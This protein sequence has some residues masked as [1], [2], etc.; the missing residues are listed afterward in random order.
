MENI[1]K[2]TRVNFKGINELVVTFKTDESLGKEN[3]GK[4]VKVVETDT[5]GAATDGDLFLGEML[6]FEE[7]GTCS[8][9]MEGYFELTYSGTA[10]ELGYQKLVSDDNG[11]V[12]S[13]AATEDGT[14]DGVLARVIRVDKKKKIVG[15]FI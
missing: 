3:E 11:N 4:L 10:P 6:K 9:R 1:L 13:A 12:K 14:V 8:V 15:F 7:R 5:V 2:P